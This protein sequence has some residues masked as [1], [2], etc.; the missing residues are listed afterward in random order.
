[1]ERFDG[2]DLLDTVPIQIGRGD[3]TDLSLQ[4]EFGLPFAIF[5]FRRCDF[6]EALITAEVADILSVFLSMPVA[7]VSKQ[8]VF[9]DL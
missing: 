5:L 8:T 6:Q 9:E 1:M 7:V 4:D 3:L 2:H